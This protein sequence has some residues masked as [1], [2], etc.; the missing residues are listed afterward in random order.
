MPI[1][2]LSFRRGKRQKIDIP[3]LPPTNISLNLKPKDTVEQFAKKNT[4][5]KTKTEQQTKTM[6]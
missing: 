3:P 4:Q 5:K 2:V 1:I 6:Y